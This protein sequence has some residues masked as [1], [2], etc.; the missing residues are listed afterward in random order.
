MK[1]FAFRALGVALWLQVSAFAGQ[2]AL[3]H[4]LSAKTLLSPDAVIGLSFGAEAVA[5]LL[6]GFLVSF[7]GR[8]FARRELSFRR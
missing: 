8:G 5:F 3:R 6:I 1:G 2:L 4:I 7:L